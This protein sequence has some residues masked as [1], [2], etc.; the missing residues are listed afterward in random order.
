MILW[1]LLL[2]MVGE[3]DLPYAAFNTEED[4]KDAIEQ[5]QPKLTELKVT[6]ECV[7]F[8]RGNPT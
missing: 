7:P 1:V 2:T 3:P 8:G 6:A 5:A 4:C